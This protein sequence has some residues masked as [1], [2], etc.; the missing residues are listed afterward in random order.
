MLKLLDAAEA[1]AQFKG[2]NTSLLHIAHL[3]AHRAGAPVHPGRR[4]RTM[5]R[6]HV[7]VVVEEKP[8]A[9]KE[10]KEEKA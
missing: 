1:N 8:E 7:E 5:K 9:K 10:Q 4:G 6:T 2:L 3:C